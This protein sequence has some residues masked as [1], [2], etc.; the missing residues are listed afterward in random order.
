[1]SSVSNNVQL[2]L[3]DGTVGAALFQIGNGVAV[4]R[5]G[6]SIGALAQAELA[7]IAADPEVE[8]GEVI[9]SKIAAK[10]PAPM[11]DTALRMLIGA[12]DEWQRTHAL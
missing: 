2:V 8:F 1:M 4:T 5:Q 9:A 11:T 3:S 10:F 12:A 6:Q 7:D